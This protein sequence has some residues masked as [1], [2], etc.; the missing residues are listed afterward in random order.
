MYVSKERPGTY[1]IGTVSSL[2]TFSPGVYVSKE[3]PGTYTVA[4]G[5]CL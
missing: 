5:V 2:Y 4:R 3:R 1:T